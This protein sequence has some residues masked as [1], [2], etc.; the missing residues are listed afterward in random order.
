MV[1]PRE[2]EAELDM[3]R[4]AERD[5]NSGK[6]RVCARRA[7]GKAFTAS[8][9]VETNGESLSSIQCL[10]IVSESAG[11]TEDVRLAATRLMA[12]V[13]SGRGVNVSVAP[14]DDALLVINAL[15]GRRKKDFL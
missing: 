13:S 10:R 3:A 7:V 8:G 2:I 1:L 5:G 9:C 12:S 4:G 14:V 6:S 11:M 15:L